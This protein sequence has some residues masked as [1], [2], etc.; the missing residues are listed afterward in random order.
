MATLPD[1]PSS[2]LWSILS[3]LSP[4][5]A[6]SF[7][8]ASSDAAHAAQES[9]IGAWRAAAQR[10]VP[11]SWWSRSPSLVDASW[12][13]RLRR[14]SLVQ[15]SWVGRRGAVPPVEWRAQPAAGGPL[16][17]VKSLGN[18]SFATAGGDGMVRVVRPRY[19]PHG[20]RALNDGALQ[21]L[22]KVGR[23]LALPT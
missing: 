6:G 14:W 4:L 2:A 3:A 7:L 23:P 18:G 16:F 1:L 11:A 13:E 22:G 17:C 20:R 9:D 10:E 19:G 21:R 12:R 15:A 5:D 8:R